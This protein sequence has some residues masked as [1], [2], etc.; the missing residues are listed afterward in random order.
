MSVFKHERSECL[1]NEFLEKFIKVLHT[2]PFLRLQIKAIII[3]TQKFIT[4]HKIKYQHHEYHNVLLNYY[5]YLT[6]NDIPISL[7]YVEL[8]DFLLTESKL[9]KYCNGVRRGLGTFRFSRHFMTPILR[10]NRSPLSV[11][12]ICPDFYETDNILL[13]LQFTNP[14]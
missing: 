12:A 3:E 7:T 13:H 8:L 2:I 4:L 10:K 6:L 1:K 14:H 11:S 9:K 5:F